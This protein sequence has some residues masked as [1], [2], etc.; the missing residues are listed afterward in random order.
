VAPFYVCAKCENKYVPRTTGLEMKPEKNGVYV[1]EMADFGPYKV[2]MADLWI[3]PKCGHKVIGGFAVH[4]IREHYQ[5]GFK[6][7][8]ELAEASNAV[9][10]C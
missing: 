6:E 3:C 7:I 5:D 10:Y 8:L 4:P 9:Y 2:W 1:I